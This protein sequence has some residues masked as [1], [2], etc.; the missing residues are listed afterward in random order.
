MRRIISVLLAGIVLLLQGAGSAQAAPAEGVD[1]SVRCSVCGM[2]VAK[3][4]NWLAQI[5]LADGTV[6]YFDGVKDLLVFYFDPGGYSKATS[7]D[8]KEIWVRDYYSLQWL[9]GRAAFYVIGSDVYGPMGKEFVPFASREAA[10]SFLR[11][12]KGERILVFGEISNDQVQSMR[13]GM[14]MRHGGE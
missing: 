5:R 14:K 6:M 11:D 3:Y 13:V 1:P 4:D 8:I 7:K 10:N 9:D 12:H 2:F